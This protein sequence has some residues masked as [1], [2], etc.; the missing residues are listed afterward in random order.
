MAKPENC[1]SN[2]GVILFIHRGSKVL[3]PLFATRIER[4]KR[5]KH[6]TSKGIVTKEEWKALMRKAFRLHRRHCHL[7]EGHC[8]KQLHSP[9]CP[10]LA[11]GA[12]R[13]KCVAFVGLAWF[14]A[15]MPRA[16]D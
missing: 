14:E 9:Q 10:G 11:T 3:K 1:G 7:A 2:A 5:E 6:L 12:S 16:R 4:G 15:G 13:Q 8:G